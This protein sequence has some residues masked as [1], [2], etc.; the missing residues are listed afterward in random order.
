MTGSDDATPVG[1][2]QNS[3]S[4]S[5]PRR[6]RAL[7]DSGILSDSA[8]P[9]IDVKSL[10]KRYGENEAVKGVSFKVARGEVFAFLGPNGAGKTTTIRMLCT[11]T[12][13][14]SGSATVDGFDVFRQPTAVRRRIGLVFQEPTLD[15]QLTAEENLQFHAVLYRVPRHQVEERIDRVLR[16][17]DLG[18]RRKDLVSTFSG[19]MARRLE[20][21]RGML[22]TPAVLF[23]D[24]P[25]IGLDPQTRALM[26]ED[27]LR[28][29]SEEG[30]TI[31]LTT[32]YMDEAEYAD[33]IAIIDNGSIVALDSPDELKKMVG[34]DTV[35]L[36]TADDK[37]AGSNLEQAGYK[38]SVGEQSVVAFVE[39][40][41]EQVTAI[42]STAGV[43]IRSV[44]V[45]RPDLDD[46]FLH[47]TGR[48]IREGHAERSFPMHFRS[49][50]R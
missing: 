49:F 17:V 15:Q 23:L 22:H 30:V 12:R 1:P 4:S 24:E 36:S 48:E 3:S 29:R 33:R 11:L 40:G 20:I 50:R 46:V 37:L 39:N 47:F 18:E 2:A 35:E 13:P 14:T 44:K 34:S 31:F 42:I 41:E 5:G 7:E 26:W 6:E 32:H 16:L 43:P 21:A 27:V 19:G 8:P 25:T 10:S 9:A 28:L 38:V 45:H